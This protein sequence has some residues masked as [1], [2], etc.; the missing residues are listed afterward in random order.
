MFGLQEFRTD[1]D[2][3]IRNSTELTED[4]KVT[5]LKSLQ[6]SEKLREYKD[7]CRN[8]PNNPNNG[9]SGICQCTLGLYRI[10]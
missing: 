5:I 6:D 8:C 1:I 3:K 7:A 10:T 2:N 4:Q 9:G